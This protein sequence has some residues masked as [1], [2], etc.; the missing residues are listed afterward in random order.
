[1]KS[2]NKIW[3]ITLNKEQRERFDQK[4][5]NSRENVVLTVINPLL[6]EVEM[7]ST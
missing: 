4:K 7:H 6:P 5:K 2:K 1:M 3:D